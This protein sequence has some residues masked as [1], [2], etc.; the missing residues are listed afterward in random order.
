[1]STQAIGV[2]ADLHARRD[3]ALARITDPRTRARILGVP[4]RLPEAK[5]HKIDVNLKTGERTATVIEGPPKAQ[6]G[7]PFGPPV[8]REH[9][10]PEPDLSYQ[11]ML[12]HRRGI[13]YQRKFGREPDPDVTIAGILRAVSEAYNVTI[14]NLVTPNRSDKFCR[15]RFAAMKLM[16]DLRC[17][18]Y[19]RI[20]FCLGKLDHTSAMHGY[21]RAGEMYADGTGWRA[22]YDHALTLLGKRP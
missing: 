10:D 14:Y 18:S 4:V 16:R 13:R 8:R 22:R 9:V 17:M 11:Q 21:R 6:K 15:P 12:A 5:T 3:S 7:N 2:V 1:M 19:P 20:G